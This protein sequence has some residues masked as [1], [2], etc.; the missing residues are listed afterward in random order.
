MPDYKK[1]YEQQCAQTDQERGR[2]ILAEWEAFYYGPIGRRI[3]RGA[4]EVVRLKN[5]DTRRDGTRA[6]LSHGDSEAQLTVADLE[7]LEALA[8]LYESDL[9]AGERVRY[10]PAK[11][12]AEQLKELFGVVLVPDSITARIGTLRDKLHEA[13]LEDGPF[14]LVESSRGNGKGYRLSGPV[15]FVDGL[16]RELGDE[17]LADEPK[18]EDLRFMIA[19]ASGCLHAPALASLDEAV[20]ESKRL[21]LACT[22]GL[23]SLIYSIDSK[24]DIRPVR[25]TLNEFRPART[26]I[27]PHPDS[28]WPFGS[29]PAQGV[30]P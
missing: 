16:A 10:A 23:H 29:N 18:G 21:A 12:V 8:A 9:V 28:G 1:L 20:E 7:I 19:T 4:V 3:R 25:S 13:G 24:G 14:R 15:R 30:T 27:L 2:R 6:V 5:V 22:A 17:Y 11:R 26:R